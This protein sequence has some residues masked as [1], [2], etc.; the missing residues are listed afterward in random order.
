MNSVERNINDVDF[1]HPE[2]SGTKQFCSYIKTL[3]E[4]GSY[5]PKFGEKKRKG[6]VFR[7]QKHMANLDPPGRFVKRKL[8]SSGLVFQLLSVQYTQITNKIYDAL[9]KEYGEKT[10]AENETKKK[11]KRGKAKEDKRFLS[12]ISFLIDDKSYDHS[13]DLKRRDLVCKI[14]MYM[15]SSLP[16]GILGKF[17]K[18]RINS[19]ICREYARAKDKGNTPTESFL[20]YQGFRRTV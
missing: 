14:E 20:S 11:A 12:I 4:D 15:A 18:K 10:A 1:E 7:I 17:D 8:D 9:N 13:D 2:H 6:V 16:N 19:A 5:N 3:V